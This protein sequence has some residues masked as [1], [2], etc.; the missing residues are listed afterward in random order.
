V[1]V[2]CGGGN[3]AVVEVGSCTM[4]M[5]DDAVMQGLIVAIVD[6]MFLSTNSYCYYLVWVRKK[7]RVNYFFVVTGKQHGTLSFTRGH[8]LPQILM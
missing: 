4:V 1:V 3:V 6:L 7:F 5:Y 2:T 8:G